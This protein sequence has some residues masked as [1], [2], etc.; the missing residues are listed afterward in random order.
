MREKVK[1][2]AHVEV[3]VK[4]PEKEESSSDEEE[5]SEP[6]INEDHTSCVDRAIQTSEQAMTT[7]L[8]SFRKEHND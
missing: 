1:T 5:K 8:H 4:P 6:Q 7:D 3:K 2:P